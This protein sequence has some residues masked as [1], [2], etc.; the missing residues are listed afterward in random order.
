MSALDDIAAA[1][2]AIREK[3]EE[4]GNATQ[5]V[6]QEVDEASATQSSLGGTAMIEGLAQLS[7]EI[8]ALA[9]QLS[10]AGETAKQAVE[11]ARAL[12]DGT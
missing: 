7:G 5:A 9:Q 12:A 3:I 1:I 6:D 4:A 10:G 11:T 2:D 8:E